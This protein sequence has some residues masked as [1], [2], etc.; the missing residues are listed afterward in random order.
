M[1]RITRT[2][3][4]ALCAMTAMGAVGCSEDEPDTG[5]RI[6]VPAN[7]GLR[8]E[9][10]QAR[11]DCAEGLACVRNVC[12]LDEFPIS[13]SARMCDVIE[14]MTAADCVQLVDG[15]SE[16]QEVC[17]EG[18]PEACAQF[19]AACNFVCEA[20]RCESRCSDDA[21]CGPGRCQN[22]ICVQ[23]VEGGDCDDDERCVRGQCV[24]PC[25]DDLACPLFHSCVDGECVD[26]G[27]RADRECVG[28][29]RNVDA[30]CLEG[31]CT[32]PCTTDADCDDPEN[33]EFTKC[34]SG[35]CQHV[36]CESDDEC[37]ARLFGSDPVEG[38]IIDVVCREGG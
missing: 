4:L 26:T 9:S 28:L 37:R 22:G 1:I 20:N 35:Q 13:P 32:A 15:C 24:E 30:R 18:E 14:C 8:G 29:L 2:W 27:C 23:C 3:I 33:Y 6:T 7:R 25:L 16:L 31:V 11:N 10:C 19:E 21:E 34:V 38:D 17:A 36:G 12:V 5:N